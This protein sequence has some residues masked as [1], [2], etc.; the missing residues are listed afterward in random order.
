MVNTEF[1]KLASIGGG[2]I[3]NIIYIIGA[4]ALC[5]GLFFL[6]KWIMKA[7]K[8]QRAFT[9][10]ADIVDMNGVI[11]FDKLAFIKSDATGLLEM[12]FQNRKTDSIP[13]IPKDLIRNGHV[14]LL[15]YAPG[16]YA[17]VDTAK[18]IRNLEIGKSFKES[19][20]LHNL[21]M[22][23]YITSKIREI[24]NKSEE[25]KRKWE[26]RGPWI[27]LGIT[28]LAAIILAAFFFWFGLERDAAN[29]AIRTQQC[30]DMGWR[31]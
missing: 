12:N 13:P 16:H 31:R 21:G 20:V 4:V 28:I 6:T 27:T 10:T 24:L 25:N 23:K 1:G 29:L 22:K 2:L 30:I 18:T 15:N 9:T 14:M 26:V 8:K 11:E 7:T 5:T 3:M 17:V 19:L